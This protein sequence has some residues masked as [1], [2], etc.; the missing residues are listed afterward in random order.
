MDEREQIDATL[1]RSVRLL[2]ES[3]SRDVMPLRVSRLVHSAIAPYLAK[4]GNDGIVVGRVWY[5]DHLLSSIRRMVDTGDDVM[6]I[7]QALIELRRVADE[8]SVDQLIEFH[9]RRSQ[10]HQDPEVDAALMA[11]SV[12]LVVREARPDNADADTSIVGVRT[13]QADLDRIRDVADRAHALATSVTAHR[14]EDPDEIRITEEEVE[15]LLDDVAAIY[16]RWSLILR[17]VDV[18]VDIQHF[19]TGKKLARAMRLFDQDAFV[20]AVISYNEA[21]RNAGKPPESIHD[22]EERVRVEYRVD[23]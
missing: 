21:Q 1:D 16:R 17:R 11:D 19:T 7:R 13:V 3:W 14:L 2:E 22:L 8:L 5:R 10:G 23:E 6:S 18:D 9:R 20:G 4:F 12:R 15:Q